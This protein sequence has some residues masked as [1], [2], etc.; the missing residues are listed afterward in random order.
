MCLGIPMQVLETDGFTARCTGRGEERRVN[1]MLI[2][3]MPEGGWVLVH[4]DRAVRPLEAEEVEPLNRA[5]DAILLAAKGEN[6]D[7]LFADLIEKA[8]A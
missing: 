5:L 8:T 3:D 4:L 1:V 6:V 7:H 2:E